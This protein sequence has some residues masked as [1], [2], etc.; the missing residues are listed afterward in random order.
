MGV[1][2]PNAA[3]VA[4]TTIGFAIDWHMPKGMML[5]MGLLSMMLASGTLVIT[6]LEG[7]TI[8][9]PGAMPKLHFSMAP[10]QT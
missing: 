10:M 6:K 1:N 5:S 4:A 8:K 2:A 3:A 7:R 9:E